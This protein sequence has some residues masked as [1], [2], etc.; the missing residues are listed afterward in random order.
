MS[1]PRLILDVDGV[2]AD[3]ATPALEFLN[4]IGKPKRYD[5]VSQWD[6]F[7]GNKEVENYFKE[8]L[9]S[10]PGYC[11]GLKPLPNACNF[12]AAAKEKYEI[13]IVTTPYDVPYWLNERTAW[14]VDKFGL[15]RSSIT[16]THK[17]QHVNGDVM[18]EDNIDNLV[19]WYSC[20]PSRRLPLI[21]DHPWNRESDTFVHRV[22]GFGCISKKLE[23]FDL[24]AVNW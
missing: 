23:E 4:M 11:Y 16:F 7:E 20:D 13:A 14:I 22:S 17:K 1:K 10:K 19:N 6:I 15:P 18:I 2:L 3:F 21:M 12:V 8:T 5:Q 9:A 24:P